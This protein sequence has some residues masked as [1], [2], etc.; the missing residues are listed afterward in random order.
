MSDVMRR[1]GR[2]RNDEQPG[3]QGKVL[4][5]L[6]WTMAEDAFGGERG[7]TTHILHVVRFGEK[8]RGFTPCVRHPTSTEETLGE[9]HPGIAI[10]K[11]NFRFLVQ[12][13]HEERRNQ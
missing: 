2:W 9:F 7:Y 4:G 6:Y 10:S 11:Q 3:K 5:A 8:A 13:N 12:C 1:I